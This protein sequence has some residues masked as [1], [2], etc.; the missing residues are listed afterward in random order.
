MKRARKDKV[1]LIKQTLRNPLEN[2]F[3]IA[4]T[5]VRPYVELLFIIPSYY[6]SNLKLLSGII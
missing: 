1:R 3:R 4:R 2:V 5:K 6:L